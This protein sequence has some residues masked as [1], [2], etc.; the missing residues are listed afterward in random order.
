VSANS[1]G[2]SQGSGSG[3]RVHGDGLADD[4]AILDELADGLAG[5]G[6]GN[7]AG[8]VG[9]KPDLALAA[10]DNGCREALLRA[11]VDPIEHALSALWPCVWL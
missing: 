5:V 10:A 3:T 7:L 4:E 9:V 11:E 6:V 2:S 8:L 1:S